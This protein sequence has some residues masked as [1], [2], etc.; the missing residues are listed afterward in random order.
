MATIKSNIF[1]R[2]DSSPSGV[3]ICCIKFIQRVIQVQTHGVISDPRVRARM[4]AEE[5]QRLADIDPQRP[6]QN[7]TSLALVHSHPL[8]APPNLEAEASGL[9]DRLLSVF[10][11]TQRCGMLSVYI[12]SRLTTS[13]DALYLTATLNCL[14]TLVRTRP[15][16]ANRIVNAIFSYKPYDAYMTSKKSLPSGT[17]LLLRSVERTIRIFFTHLSKQ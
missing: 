17:K 13:S 2:T 7:E 4:T 9:L 14:A 12:S 8:L 10:Q 3:R 5:R 16:I 1:R 6:E 15:S 11:E